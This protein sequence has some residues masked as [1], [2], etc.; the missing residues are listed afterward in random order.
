MKACNGLCWFTKL[1]SSPCNENPLKELGSS[2]VG[3]GASTVLPR[4]VDTVNVRQKAWIY[5]Y[6]LTLFHF[7][8]CQSPERDELWWLSHWAGWAQHLFILKL[9]LLWDGRFEKSIRGTL[10]QQV[11]PQQSQ[12]L[13]LFDNHH[14]SF[15]K[16]IKSIYKHCY[17]VC[18]Y[19]SHWKFF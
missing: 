2:C 18:P 7:Y 15:H 8:G 3:K 9:H 13:A 12:S 10:E 16:L 14:I 1:N 19:N 6:F 11:S 17:I 4:R 5:I